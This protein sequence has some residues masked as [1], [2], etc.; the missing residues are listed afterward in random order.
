MPRR[1]SRPATRPSKPGSRGAAIR[2]SHVLDHM[3][4]RRPTEARQ[5]AQRPWQRVA[6][7]DC[8]GRLAV[9]HPRARQPQTLPTGVTPQT[10]DS[11][12]RARERGNVVSVTVPR[13]P[14]F[15]SNSESLPYLSTPSR[16]SGPPA[17][18]VCLP[19][20]LRPGISKSGFATSVSSRRD[21]ASMARWDS[22]STTEDASSSAHI[23]SS[24]IHSLLRPAATPSSPLRSIHS[25]CSPR[26]LR[27]GVRLPG[28]PSAA[29]DRRSWLHG[30]R[31]GANRPAA[32]AP[33]VRSRTPGAHHRR[34]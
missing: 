14:R 9:R 27:Q 17:V 7:P 10:R 2:S 20:S 15:N 6:V 5:V 3:H 28:R 16:S 30:G 4:R 13:V 21:S 34:P 12:A 24:S 32:R 19:T 1:N 25:A 8:P 26:I 18:G 33:M 29:T 22:N 23:L 11:W 31:S